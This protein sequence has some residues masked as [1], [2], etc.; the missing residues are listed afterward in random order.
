MTPDRHDRPETL[1]DLLRVL[2]VL[3]APWAAALLI[4]YFAS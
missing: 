3:I 1:G 4:M 2:A